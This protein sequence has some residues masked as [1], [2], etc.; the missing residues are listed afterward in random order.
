MCPAT[1][2]ETAAGE[3][4]SLA[5]ANGDP[6]NPS[7]SH[8]QNENEGEQVSA[9][10]YDPNQDRREVEERRFGMQDRKNTMDVDEPVDEEM[11]EVEED[12]EDDLDDMFALDSAPKKKVGSSFRASSF[13]D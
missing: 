8:P 5:K 3:D 6:A 2:E 9:A 10:D 4:F 1:P 11:E 12:D 7:T 13:A